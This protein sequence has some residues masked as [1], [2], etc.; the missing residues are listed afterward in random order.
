MRAYATDDTE[1]LRAQ[2]LR[3]FASFPNA[4]VSRSAYSST[5][6]LD[7]EA[8]LGRAASSSYLPQS[9]PQARR[10]RRDL[11]ALFDQFENRRAVE[12]KTVTYAL[13]ADW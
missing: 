12:L 11:L 4:R 6:R 3:I 13:V 8:L 1:A 5:Q 7:R 10:L 9:G 2:A